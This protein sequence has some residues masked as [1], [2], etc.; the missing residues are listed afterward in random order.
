M[1]SDPLLLHLRPRAALVASGGPPRKK[2][3][4]RRPE[5]GDGQGGVSAG[6]Q[7]GSR[8]RRGRHCYAVFIRIKKKKKSLR[9][10]L[11]HTVDMCDCKGHRRK[12]MRRTYIG[13]PTLFE[14]FEILTFV[15]KNLKSL[16]NHIF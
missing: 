7:G 11:A 8:G 5:R 1:S 15:L 12:K 2:R 14:I 3:P 4:G 6:A 10:N 16:K 13:L 9:L